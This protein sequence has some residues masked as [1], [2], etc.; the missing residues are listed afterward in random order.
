M[1]AHA[2][3]GV[4]QEQLEHVV[5][6]FVPQVKEENVVGQAILVEIPEIPVFVVRTNQRD[7][8]SVAVVKLSHQTCQRSL[9]VPEVRPPRRP[10]KVI[11]VSRQQLR[12]H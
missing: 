7:V 9:V 1:A 10:A 4:F 5:R 12:D 2:R 11:V 8:L 6:E 3:S